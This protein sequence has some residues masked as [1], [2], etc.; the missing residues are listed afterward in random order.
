MWYQDEGKVKGMSLR[1]GFRW[2]WAFCKKY[3]IISLYFDGSR[4]PPKNLSDLDLDLNTFDDLD[5][6]MAE[7][8]AQAPADA[9]D[10]GVSQD[11]MDVD[12]ESDVSTDRDL[13]TDG[14][15]EELKPPPTH[16]PAIG[17]PPPAH[18]RHSLLRPPIGFH[19]SGS[20][21]FSATFPHFPRPQSPMLSP[22]QHLPLFHH[23]HHDFSSFYNPFL[24]A[25]GIGSPQH[26]LTLGSLPPSSLR[27]GAS[28]PG[29]LSPQNLSLPSPQ[30]V[31]SSSNAQS[32][33]KLSSPNLKSR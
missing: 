10:P 21:A 18:M 31:A 17:L 3:S 2:W 11:D 6:L 27:Q 14:R 19:P 30:Q 16:H 5:R 23:H 4:S 7:N 13:D 24:S 20:S 32:S 25:Y 12:V 29:M 15:K 9:C 28:T 33:P 8:R 22:S 26:Q 1:K